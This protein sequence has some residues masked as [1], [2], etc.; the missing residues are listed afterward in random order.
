MEKF[1]INQIES[2]KSKENDNERKKREG[3]IK[4]NKKRG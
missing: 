2:K 1:E 3:R 4:K